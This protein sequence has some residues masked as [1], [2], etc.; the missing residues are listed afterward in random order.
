MKNFTK[1]ELIYYI[2]AWDNTGT[3][4]Y[5]LCRVDSCGKV[6]MKLADADTGEFLGN[7]FNP[8]MKKVKLGDD[9]ETAT[10]EAAKQYLLNEIAS[11]KHA[12]KV[13]I[14]NN[15]HPKYLEHKKIK[16]A[17]LENAEP[18]AMLYKDAVTKLHASM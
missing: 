17:E 11:I 4:T 18:K 15:A 9:V 16:L 13:G 1:G 3:F 10:L 7:N 2:N 6:Q 8:M 5:R 12:I 14:E